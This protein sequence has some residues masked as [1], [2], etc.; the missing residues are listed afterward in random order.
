MKVEILYMAWNRKIFTQVTLELLKR[1]TDWK[2]VDKLVIYDD[3]S[4]DGT[5]RVIERSDIGDLVPAFEI[6]EGGWGSVGAT[7]N[8]YISLTEATHF[9][10]IDNDIA[11]PPGW[12]PRLLSAAERHDDYEL[13]GMEA[14]WSGAYQG[15]LPSKRYTVVP[16]RHIGG[17][18]LMR[19]KAFE[20]R[21][22]VPLA[23]GKEGRNGFTI[24]QH[25]WHLRAGW[26]KPDLP[27]VQLDKIPV[28]PWS[29]LASR[30]V[31]KGWARAWDPF[32][33]DMHEWWDWIPQDVLPVKKAAA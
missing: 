30:Y 14:G 23:L 17:V 15:L 1:N 16:A 2:H 24:W 5:R 4:K 21:K 19:T 11:M 8:D 22:P 27:N 28:P 31:E 10:K 3:G 13:I 32:T 18:G 20:W 12:L 26:L 25:R 7:M 29:T 33:L 6:R 9:V